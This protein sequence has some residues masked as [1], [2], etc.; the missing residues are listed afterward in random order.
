MDWKEDYVLGHGP[1]DE[2]HRDFADA[3]TD[4]GEAEGVESVLSSLDALI[5]HTDEHFAQEQRWMEEC[6]FPPIH[7]HEGEHVRVL[8]S[9][10][11]MR[12]NI[13]A[14]P[15][16]A[17]I[18]ARELEVWFAQHAAT[19]DDALAFYMRQVDYVPTAGSAKP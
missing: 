18:L 13:Q 19:M 6:G 2:T 4:L 10:K 1:M 14:D 17:R 11:D 12:P 3:V 15:G 9:L 5:E 16:I 7:C 8:Q